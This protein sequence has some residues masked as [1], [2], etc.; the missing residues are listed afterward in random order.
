MRLSGRNRDQRLTQDGILAGTPA[1][2]SPE[3]AANGD[4]LGAHS[5]LYSLG[6]VAYFLLTGVPPFVRDTTAETLAAHLRDPVQPLSRHQERIPDD[7]QAIVSKCLEKNSSRR[8]QSARE[9]A[10]SLVGC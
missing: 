7:V 1:Y 9:L 8:F 6:A 2:M 10:E 5:D 4:N 3:Q